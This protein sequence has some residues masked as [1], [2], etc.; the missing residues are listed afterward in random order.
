[1]SERLQLTQGLRRDPI[2]KL[3]EQ[4]YEGM[5]YFAGTGPKATC[6][7]CKCWGDGT[8]KK[9][10][11]KQRACSRFVAITGMGSQRV[12]GDAAACKYFEPTEAQKR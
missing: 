12:P 1:M 6:I 11:T 4:S 10:R 3:A 7:D 2:D 8:G 9:Q 5:A